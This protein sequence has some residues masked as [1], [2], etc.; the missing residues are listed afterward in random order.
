MQ[1]LYAMIFMIDICNS[2][3][4]LIEIIATAVFLCVYSSVPYLELSFLVKGLK[5]SYPSEVRSF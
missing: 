1:M 4:D 5:V 3:A 2:Y